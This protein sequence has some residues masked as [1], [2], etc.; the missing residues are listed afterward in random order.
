MS[1]PKSKVFKCQYDQ[2]GSV[3]AGLSM[4]LNVQFETH[5]DGSFDD[6]VEI[7]TEG[8]KVPVRLNLHA[9]RAGPDIQFEP[10]VN[11]KFIPM[12]H[13]KTE[14]V[15]F[16]NEGKQTG[17]VSLKEEVRSKSGII[18]EPTNFSLEP[19]QVKRVK[20]GLLADT[21]EVLTKHVVV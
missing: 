7:H 16:K 19:N 18:M 11:L 10:L 4:K 12:G 14:M 20:I 17:H 1:Q 8:Y 13:E 9:L 5:D 6:Y 3:A 2:S 15:E 21:P